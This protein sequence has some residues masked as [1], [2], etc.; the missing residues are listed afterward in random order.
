[1]A[2]ENVNVRIRGELR[3]HL[4]QQIGEEGI[5]ENASEYIRSLIR[6][7]LKTRTESWNWLR[8]HLEPALRAD[9]SIFV[10]VSAQ[11]VINRNKAS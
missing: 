6:D 9:E 3:T 10:A 5:Y 2:S 7:D 4:Q 8:Q 1:M 11:D